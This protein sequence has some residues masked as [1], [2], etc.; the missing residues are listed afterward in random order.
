MHAQGAGGDRDRRTVHRLDGAVHGERHRTAHHR[1]RVGH[2]RAR[3]AAGDQGAPGGVGAV[4]EGLGDTGEPRLGGG[5]EQPRAGQA[6][7]GQRAARQ[8]HPGH[9]G[10]GLVVVVDG[11]VVERAVRLDVGDGGPGGLGEDPERADLVRHLGGQFA[12]RDV[13][14]APSEAR[15]VAVGDLGP[16]PHPALRG[17]VADA[18]HHRGVAR[19]EA[20]GDVGAGDDGEQGVVVG[21]GPAAEAFTEICVEV[22]HPPKVDDR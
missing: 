9:D 11:A 7:H 18:T 10:T 5:R 20:A 21:E 3:L 19:V 13:H 17:E 6:E 8:S 16:D 1:V 12:G 22:D 14:G 15:Q 2:H 4:G